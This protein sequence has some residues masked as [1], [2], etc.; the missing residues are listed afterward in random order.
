MGEASLKCVPRSSTGGS[1]E[2]AIF[3]R[4][5]TLLAQIF[6]SWDKSTASST[7]GPALW[8]KGRSCVTEV[9]Q[10]SAISRTI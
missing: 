10:L 7:L 6:S 3:L 1:G 2:K 4:L 8:C 9:L 5:R